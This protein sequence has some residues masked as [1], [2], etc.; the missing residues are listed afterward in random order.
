MTLDKLLVTSGYFIAFAMG[1]PTLGSSALMTGYFRFA[2]VLAYRE[3]T[4][5]L[6]RLWSSI[7]LEQ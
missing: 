7:H 5:S 2:I 3:S 6:G 1:I 4:R